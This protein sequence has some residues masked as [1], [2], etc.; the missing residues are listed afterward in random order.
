MLPIASNAKDFNAGTYLLDVEIHF[1]AHFTSFQQI[2]FWS[3]LWLD[4]KGFPSEAYV[5]RLP[6]HS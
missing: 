3:I 5:A 6:N 2:Q 4:P 1:S